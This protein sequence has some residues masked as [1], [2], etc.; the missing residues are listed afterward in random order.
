MVQAWKIP[1]ILKGL[2]TWVP[3]LDHWRRRRATSGGSDSA[4]YCYSVWL[5]HL[6]VLSSNGF[7]VRGAQVG[8]LGP[9]DSIGTGLAALLSGAESYVGL[10]LVPFSANADLAAMLQE[11][12]HMY[13]NCEDIPSHEEF[14]GIRPR[15]DSYAFPNQLI[16]GLDLSN[17]VE[18]IEREVD[19][20]LCKSGVIAYRAP[21]NS[22]G[23]INSGSLDLIFSQAVLE[24]V[25]NLDETYKAMFAWLKPGGYASHVIDFGAHQLSPFWNGHWAYNDFQWRLAR[26]RREFLLNREPFSTHVE[27]VQRA[28]LELLQVIHYYDDNGLPPHYLSP[29]FQQFSAEDGRTRVVMLVLQKR[30]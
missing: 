18:A 6:N 27:C 26:G 3:G 13:L 15:L 12:A 22:P 2:M 9:G 4:R 23:V 7:R 8:E 19:R 11:L 24:H 5:R 30:I 10:D 16:N 17:R 21:W 1:R 25:D 28:G 20:G 29:Q 14:P